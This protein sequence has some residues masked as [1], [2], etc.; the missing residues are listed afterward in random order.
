MMTAPS[1][2]KTKSIDISLSDAQNSP[3]PVKQPAKV[4]YKAVKGDHVDE[5]VAKLVRDLNIKIPV[6]RVKPG[7]YVIGTDLKML[8]IK[9]EICM[10]R[11]GGGYERLDEYVKRNQD[12][13]IDKIKKLIK[14]SGKNF[15][16]VM[17]ELLKKYKAENLVIDSFT[18]VENSLYTIF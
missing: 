9:G 10:V 12:I 5:L 4:V 14:E 3:S 11:V 7:R 15:R 1:M 16:F 6:I 17:V 13:E 2:E 8:V 18:K